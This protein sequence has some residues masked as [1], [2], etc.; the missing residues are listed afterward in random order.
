MLGNCCWLKVRLKITESSAERRS[1]PLRG[2]PLPGLD[3]SSLPPAIGNDDDAGERTEAD[4]APKPRRRAATKTTRT[5]R[6]GGDDE[7]LEA[8]G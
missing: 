1:E 5:R 7:A 6:S 3:P 8:I 2:I 4:E